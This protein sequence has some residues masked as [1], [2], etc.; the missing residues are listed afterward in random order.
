MPRREFVLLLIL[1][2][3]PLFIG[4]T[5]L[6]RTS[7]Y[8][9]QEAREFDEYTDI[10]TNDAKHRLDNFAIQ[11]QNE[12]G[13]QGYIIA[14]GGGRC[15]NR[16]QAHANLAR[17]YMIGNRG[18]DQA[19]LVAISAGRRSNAKVYTVELWVVP[20][21]ATPPTPSPTLRPCPR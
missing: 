5:S 14:Y 4:E 2:L 15:P 8:P 1:T 10:R 12:P 19:R 9:S 18:I 7:D 3:I 6:A 13:A 11:L 20:L 16:A 21:G 17:S